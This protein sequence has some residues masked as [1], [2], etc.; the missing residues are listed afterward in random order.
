M[1]P[2]WLWQAL[3]APG[4]V[5]LVLLFVVPFYAVIG[6]AFGTL[7]PI[8]QN[9]IPIWNPFDWNFDNTMQILAQFA[10][11]ERYWQVFARTAVYIFFAVT[12]SLLIAY[13]VAYYISRHARR[14][15]VILLVLLVLPF[16]VSY[17]MRM[18]A[19]VG[20]LAPDGLINGFLV[21][22][23]IDTDPPNWLGGHPGTVIFGLIYGYIPYMILPLVAALDRIDK[24]LLEASRDLGMTAR[25]TFF[26]VT[27]PLSKMGILGGCV[28]VTLPMFGD[29]YTPMI[30]SGSPTTSMLGN[31]IYLYFHGGPQPDVGA[32]LTIVLAAF[33]AVLMAYYLY[34][35]A[36]AQRELQ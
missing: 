22:S 12:I 15:K 16:W 9:P 24:N 36:K 17:L 3:A 5:W 6:V 31:Q 14:T 34:S 28:I 32:T 26:R 4:V 35:V 2:R 30:M 19:W 10:P 29:Y 23:G 21:W 18:L 7:D 20:L 33:L 1:Y 8:F 25:Q 11:G 27:L 13:P